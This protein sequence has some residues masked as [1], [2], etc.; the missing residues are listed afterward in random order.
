MEDVERYALLMHIPEANEVQR[1]LHK[2]PDAT[3]IKTIE[4]PKQINIVR[5]SLICSHRFLQTFT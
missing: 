2:D 1:N 3:A 5:G 4:L